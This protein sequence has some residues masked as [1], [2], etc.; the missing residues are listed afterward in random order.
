MRVEFVLGSKT[1]MARIYLPLEMNLYSTEHEPVTDG[2][3]CTLCSHVVP[4]ETLV[5]VRILVLGQ[6]CIDVIWR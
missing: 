1:V 6:C 5:L 3:T 4:T 2:F